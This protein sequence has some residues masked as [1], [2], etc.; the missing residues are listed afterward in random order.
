MRES[1]GRITTKQARDAGFSSSM[2]QLLV[3]QGVAVKENRRV[4]ALADTPL[5]D[6]AVISLRWPKAVFRGSS[7]LYLHGMTDIVLGVYEISLPQGY[8]QDG[9]V[10]E[11]PN[12]LVAHENKSRGGS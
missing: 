2:L 5:D 7:S 4:F 9:I 3:S 1:G 10:K 12:C 11:F 8:K 6:F